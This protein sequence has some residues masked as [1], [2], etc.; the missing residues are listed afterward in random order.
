M[1]ET[2]SS[3]IKF[4]EDLQRTAAFD[5]NRTYPYLFQQLGYRKRIAEDLLHSNI[6]EYTKILTE[7]YNQVNSEI[8]LILGLD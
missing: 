4:Y 6:E 3:R 2:T 1:E 7:L 5:A 8:K